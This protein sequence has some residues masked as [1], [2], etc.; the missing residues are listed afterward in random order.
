MSRFKLNYF[1]LHDSKRTFLRFLLVGSTSVALDFIVYVFALN[2]GLSSLNAKAI[3]TVVATVFSFFG[4]R[5]FAFQKST[6]GPIGV[7]FFIFIY[8]ITLLINVG[9]N[10]LMLAMLDNSVVGR[11]VIAFLVATG[12][13]A[14]CNFL[15]M[16]FFVFKGRKV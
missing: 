5:Y 7:I 13:A 11:Y 14:I 9:S 4:N 16:K 10:E 8:G 2:L 12:I 3:S 6:H 15:G 1:A